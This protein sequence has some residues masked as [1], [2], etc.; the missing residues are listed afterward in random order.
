MEKLRGSAGSS[1]TELK[2]EIVSSG[3]SR[4]CVLEERDPDICEELGNK[5]AW[6]G[7]ALNGRAERN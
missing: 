7:N 1:R 5:D 6:D 2:S 4:E 3:R